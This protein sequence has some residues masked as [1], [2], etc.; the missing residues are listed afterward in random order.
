MSDAFYNRLAAT[1]S[2]L[3]T[4]FGGVVSVSRTTGGSVD[5][6]TGAVTPGSTTTL[7]AKGLITDFDTKLM[8]GTAIQHGDRLLVIDNTFEPLMTDRPVIGSQQ[9][10]IVSIMAK[11]P[12]NVA[13]VYMV[14]VRL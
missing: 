5:P 7:T 4:K 14:Q 1:A 13:V 9:W 10:N 3:L 6:I 8:D 12:A 11:Q 2:K